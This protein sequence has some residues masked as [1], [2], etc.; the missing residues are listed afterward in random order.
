MLL[1]LKNL[2]FTVFIPGTVAGWGPYWILTAGGAPLPPAS[3]LVVGLPVGLLGVAIYLWC[4]W[5]FAANGR[6]TPGPWDPPKTLVVRGLY[7]YMRNPMYVGVL[8][9]IAGWALACRSGAVARYGVAVAL[10]FHLW[11]MVFEEPQLR[12]LF[13]ES[14]VAYTKRVRRW[15]PGRPAA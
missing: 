1:A 11:I 3:G 14:Y 12:R 8:L 9:V 7:R 2:L 15:L 6:G 4:L 10:G 13:G 5:D